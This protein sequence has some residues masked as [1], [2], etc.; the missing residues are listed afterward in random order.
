MALALAY[1]E[2][3]AFF[4]SAP[5]RSQIAAFRLSDA[6][7]GRIRDLLQKKSAGTL[8]ADETEEL[9]HGV[10]LDQLIMQIRSRARQQA[11]AG[12]TQDRSSAL[13]PPTP[14]AVEESLRILKQI[15]GSLNIP[16]LDV[17]KHDLYKESVA[18]PI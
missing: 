15:S 14:N 11:E 1:E 8:S 13:T 9:D 5:T 17:S 2:I 7:I 10:M 6:A 3:V 16:D 4:A 18:H 12:E